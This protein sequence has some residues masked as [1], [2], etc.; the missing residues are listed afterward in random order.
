MVIVKQMNSEAKQ[1]ENTK[2]PFLFLQNQA[3]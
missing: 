3:K 1:Q 2:S